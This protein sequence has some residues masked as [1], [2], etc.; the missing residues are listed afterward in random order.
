MHTY[1]AKIIA[2]NQCIFVRT[3]S[4]QVL[5]TYIYSCKLRNMCNQKAVEARL[6]VGCEIQQRYLGRKLLLDHQ[7]VSILPNEAYIDLKFLLLGGPNY[8]CDICDDPASKAYTCSQCNQVTCA[9]CYNKYKTSKVPLSHFRIATPII[10]NPTC[11][12]YK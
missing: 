4:G 9:E 10:I 7:T 5:H 1:T 6:G 8:F 3:L 12:Q 2:E 11:Y